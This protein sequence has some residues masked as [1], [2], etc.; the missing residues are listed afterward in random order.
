MLTPEEIFE[1]EFKRSMRGYDVDEVNGFLDQI[2]QDY[3]RI[4]EENIV[5]KKELKQFKGS[6][7]RQSTHLNNE[8]NLI[9]DLTRRVEALEKKTRF[10]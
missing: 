7:S 4:L 3:G 2:I 8:S 9:N 6:T 1:K 10:L 5:L